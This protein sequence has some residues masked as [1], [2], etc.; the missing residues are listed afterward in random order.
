MPVLSIS[1]EQARSLVSGPYGRASLEHVASFGVPFFIVRRG[2]FSSSNVDP[3]RNLLSN[4][5]AFFMDLGQ[6]VFAVTANHVVEASLSD[7]VVKVGLF[8]K[9][10]ELPAV[11]LVE[12]ADFEERIISRNA[13]RDIATFRVTS[14]EVEKLN[15]SILS[16][17]PMVPTECRGGIA[18]IGYPRTLRD[19]ESIQHGSDGPEIILSWAVFPGFG[20]AAS[21]SERQITFQFERSELT[22]PPLGFQH[23]DPDLDLGGMSG[24][25]LLMKCETPSGIEYWAPAGV[26]IQ[27]EMSAELN[28]GLLFASRLDNLQADGQI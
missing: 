14:E 22:D 25:P 10:F 13:D 23:P 24:G 7:T 15:A 8:P 5:T 27:G 28:G 17:P 20:I 3:A 19:I 16:T 26:I 9:R 11:P 1:E 4:G 18:F 12:M 6:G 2:T 21:V